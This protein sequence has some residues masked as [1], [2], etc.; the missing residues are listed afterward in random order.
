MFELKLQEMAT[1]EERKASGTGSG[2]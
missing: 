1:D 2:V